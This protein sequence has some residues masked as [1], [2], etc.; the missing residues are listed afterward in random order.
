MARIL[1]RTGSKDC[2]GGCKTGDAQ[3]RMVASHSA[4]R[5]LIRLHDALAERPSIPRLFDGYN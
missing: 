1:S 4:Q 3:N 5:S 2:V